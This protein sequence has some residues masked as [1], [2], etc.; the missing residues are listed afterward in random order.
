MNTKKQ[1]LNPFLKWAGG[2]RQLINYLTKYLPSAFSLSKSTYFEPFI[3][4]GA[5]FFYVLPRTAVISDINWELINCYQVIKNNVDSLI[6]LLWQYEKNHSKKNF[7]LA[8][9]LDRHPQYINLSNTEKAAR[10]IYLNKTCF[11][12]LFRVNSQNEFNV[13]FGKYDNP[14]ILEKDLLL[15]IADY[16]NSAE[17]EIIHNDFAQVLKKADFGDFIYLDPPYDPISKTASFTGY[18]VKGFGQYEQVRLKNTV[19]TLNQRGCLV[20]QSNSN[21]E[22]IEELYKDYTFEYIKAG[23]CI[24][25]NGKKRT[26]VAEVLI[27]NF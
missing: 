12:G 4:G 11:N 9:E 24:N 16:L 6:D 15:N 25:S 23:R 2:K 3:G 22:F 8:R 18:S 21:T 19:D 27:S 13:P 7:Y 17:I 26:K 20:L 10:I 5:L 1:P 14:T